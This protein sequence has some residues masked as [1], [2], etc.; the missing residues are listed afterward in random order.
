MPIPIKVTIVI[1]T[2]NHEK[3]LSAAIESVLS[4]KVDFNIQIVITDDGSTDQTQTIIKQFENRYPNT[5]VFLKSKKNK[6]INNNIFKTQDNL[7]GEYIAVLDGDDYWTNELKLQK[8]VDFLDSNKE[9]NG[10]FH[11]ARIEH[12]DNSNQV[13]FDQKYLYSQNYQYKSIIFPSDMINRN[14]ILPSSSAFFR[15]SAIRV[16]DLKLINDNYSFLWKLCC[17]MIKESKYFYINEVW[18]VY[19]NHKK[20]ISKS[21]NQLFHE[22]HIRFLKKLLSDSFYKGYKYDLYRTLSNEYKI[23]LDS[24]EKKTN[25]FLDKHFILYIQFEIKKMISYYRF[26]THK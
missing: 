16:E 19:R 18:S 7:K 13:L 20:G 15:K 24:P 1:S 23:I 6:G 10:V 3:F 22:S 9:Y 25:S 2:F 11:D 26:L 5:I 12:L 17:I 4:Q 8:Q 14:C 21:N